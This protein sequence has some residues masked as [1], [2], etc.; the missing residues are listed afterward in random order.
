MNIGEFFRI[1]VEEGIRQD[2][3]EKKGIVKHLQGIKDKYRKLSPQEKQFFDKDS[4]SNPYKDSKL[5]YGPP[6]KKVKTIMVGV[7]VE[8]PEL[9]LADRL[10]TKGK[11]IDLAISHHPQ[12]RA[13]ANFY[14]VMDIIYDV[15]KPFGIKKTKI[16]KMVTER[17]AEVERKVM[18][19]NHTRPVDAA[20]LLNIPFM[21]L[22]TVCDNF[23]YQ[24]IHKLIKTKKP[25]KVSDILNLLYAIPEYRVAAENNQPPKLILGKS[26][27]K[28]GKVLIEMTGGTEGPKNI[29]KELAKKKIKTFICIN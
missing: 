17:I 20:K 16:Q 8:T 18:P 24:Y 2:P 11:N 14:E 9:L 6:S 22:H 19:G 26:T 5:L 25:K 12:G 3:R 7:D 27:N 28:C 29:Y 21:C 1:A 10:K 13:R 23:V 15:L 4:L